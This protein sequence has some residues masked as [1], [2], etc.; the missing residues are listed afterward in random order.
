MTTYSKEDNVYTSVF[1]LF[2]LVSGIDSKIEFDIRKAA[3]ERVKNSRIHI[4]WEFVDK[5]LC[6]FFKENQYDE[7]FSCMFT[8]TLNWLLKDDCYEIFK[9]HTIPLCTKNGLLIKKNALEWLREKDN[10]ISD[11]CNNC[12]AIFDEDKDFIKNKYEK[13]GMRGL[14]NYFWDK[15]Q[16]Y[17][18]DERRLGHAEG[19][20][21]KKETDKIRAA[22][23]DIFCNYTFKLFMTAQAIIF[24]KAVYINGGT[25]DKNNAS[26]LLH[27]LYLN[28]GDRIAS[29]DNI[30]DTISE[31]ID[32]FHPIKITYEKSMY[33]LKQKIN[34][35][36]N[37]VV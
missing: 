7:N 34:H 16:Y 3:I 26:D 11:M 33:E 12:T 9:M 18:I 22:I 4:D 27:L 6:S 36:S 25:Q 10:R 30:Y 1:A 29:S 19:L 15:Y 14:S 20:C 8:Q 32:Y 21:G 37:K 2:E 35:D 31:G 28:K 17:K 24:A 13:E 5:K 23:N